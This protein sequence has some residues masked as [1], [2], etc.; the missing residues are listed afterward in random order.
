[1]DIVRQLGLNMEER[2]LSIT[3]FYNADCVFATGTMGELTP[4]VEIDGRTIRDEREVFDIVHK[5]FKA[6]I[7]SLCEP[8]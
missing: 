8:V 2:N 3:E 6:V 5:A 4:V 1:M 7:P